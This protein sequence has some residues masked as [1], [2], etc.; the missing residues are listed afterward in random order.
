[1][2][3]ISGALHDSRVQM[4]DH[5]VIFTPVPHVLVIVIQRHDAFIILVAVLR[6]WEPVLI[7]ERH[8]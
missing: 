4:L 2:S 1:M 3:V 8:L 5:Y 7:V 6:L